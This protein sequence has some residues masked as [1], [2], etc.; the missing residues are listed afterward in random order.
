MLRP[1]LQSFRRRWHP[2]YSCA[3]LWLHTPSPRR[4]LRSGVGRRARES[5]WD[6]NS[7]SNLSFVNYSNSVNNQFGV[8]SSVI[9]ISLVSARRSRAVQL[10]HRRRSDFDY[11]KLVQSDSFSRSTSVEILQ[12]E[13]AR[14][15]GARS[16]VRGGGRMKYSP[17]V[18]YSKQSSR[19]YATTLICDCVGG[20]AQ[21]LGCPSLVAGLFRIFFSRTSY[22]T[23]IVVRKC[24]RIGWEKAENVTKTKIINISHLSLRQVDGTR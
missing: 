16:R 24:W 19:T 3:T 6:T 22:W 17:T 2:P 9:W 14:R 21:R 7:A 8:R 15:V 11:G 12:S 5:G 18:T 10:S 4:R 20:V 23:V 13:R 1:L